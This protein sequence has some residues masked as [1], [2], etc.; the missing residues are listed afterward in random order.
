MLTKEKDIKALRKKI[1]TKAVKFTVQNI[2]D[3]IVFLDYV[4][5]GEN[6]TKVPEAQRMMRQMMRKPMETK[7]TTFKQKR[8]ALEYYRDCGEIENEDE[9]LL[10]NQMIV[11]PR[12]IDPNF[13]EEKQKWQELDVGLEARID[14]LDKEKAKELNKSNFIKK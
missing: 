7:K 1:I 4:V 13:E 5:V 12:R 8:W 6:N 3:F 11:D 10:I 14:H 9:R 2:D